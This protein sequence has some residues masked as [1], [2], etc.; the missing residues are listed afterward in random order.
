MQYVNFGTSGLK[1]SRIALGMMTFGTPEW[2][3]WIRDEE[4]AREVTRRAIE[5][6]ITVFDTADM[7]S[8][9]M[10]EE[11]TGRVLREFAT[12]DEIVI[13]TKVYFPVDLAFKGG[14]APGPKPAVRPNMSGLSRKR[15]LSAVDA[16]LGRLGTD[17]IDLYQIHRF[18]AATPVEETM[19]ALHDTVKAGKVRYLGASSMWAW[20][21]ARMQRAAEVHGWTKF[22]SMQN[23]YNLA[24]RE[25]E[26]EMIPFCRDTGVGVM[27][28]S[29]LARG[30][31]AGN[32]AREDKQGGGESRARTDDIALKYYYQDADFAVVDA[33]SALAK[34]KGVS[35]AVLA[36]AWLLHRPGVTAPLV[37]ASKAWQIE[38]AVKALELKL[39]PE[40]MAALEA[41]YRP[42]PVLGHT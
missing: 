15:I 2:R 6:G 13:A 10:S 25:E 31:L 36:Y 3:P 17:Y 11:I 1:V 42:H 16:S 26:R 29:P 8:A 22:I 38:E 24:Y 18:D 39:T 4:T 35:S 23:H 20:Q 28:W 41:P 21:F 5:L 27:P 37:G 9:G 30:F 7:Y 32:R 19:E 40:D 34:S 12:R 33:L 14:N